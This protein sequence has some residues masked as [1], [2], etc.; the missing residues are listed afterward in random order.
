MKILVF[1]DQKKG[2]LKKSSFEVLSE[3]VRLASACGAEVHAALLGSGVKEQAGVLAH[4]GAKTVHIVDRPELATYINTPFVTAAAAVIEAVKPRV[5][6]F[7]TSEG[8]KDYIPALV[9]KLDGA[10]ITDCCKIKWTGDGVEIERPLMAAKARSTMESS[11]SLILLTC[12]AGSFDTN[13]P[14]PA[15][16]AEIVEHAATFTDLKQIFK[17][18]LAANTGKISLDEA[19][20]VVA[21]GRGVRDAEGLKLLEELADVLGA[22][23]GST[24]AV[25]ESG[26]VSATL[27][28]GQTGKVINPTLYIGCGV[29]GAVQHTAGMGNS[30]VIV[31]INK[32]S[33]A[34]IFNIADYGLV[35]D[36][37]KVVPLLIEAVKELK[38]NS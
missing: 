29:S 31:A 16:V 12:R 24:R 25:V 1:A 26:L 36:L 32:D 21:A 34:P 10:G 23:L 35:G 8:I 5:V 2:K 4:Y 19:D 3:A 17:E 37:F 33:E 9:Q 15:A 6:L 14:N 20:I 22:A 13:E 11:H 30:K 7:P 27:Q 28:I 38:K 18:V